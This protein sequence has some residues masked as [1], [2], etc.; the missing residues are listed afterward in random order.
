MAKP[1]AK[2]SRKKRLPPLETR[3]TFQDG[4]LVASTGKA[5]R[6]AQY[7]VYDEAT[8]FERNLKLWRKTGTDADNDLRDLWVHEMRQVQRVMSYSGA[9]D[10]IVDIIEFVEDE[11]NFG[12]LL[13]HAG[14]PLS[15]KREHVSSQHWLKN[16][17]AVRA[18]SLFWQNF[19]RVVWALGIIHAQGLVH[20]NIDTAAIMTEGADEP[21]FQLTGFEWSLRVAADNPNP[22]HAKKA[23]KVVS[24]RPLK[25]SF[26]EDWK[27][28]GRL[29]G[30][31]LDTGIRSSGELY[32]LGKLKTPISLSNSERVLLKRLAAPTRTDN[33]EAQ[34]IVR[35]IDD[36]IAEVGRS[37]A[38]RAG[39]LVLMF[40]PASKLGEAVYDMTGGQIAVD[41]YRRQL[42]WVRADLDGGATLLAP[43]DFEPNTSKLQLIT[44]TMRYLLVPFRQEG[45]VTWDIGVCVTAEPRPEALSFHEQEE[46][47]LA[48]PIEVVGASRFAQEARAR[49]G[50]DALDWS[51]FASTRTSR[52][53]GGR[54]DLI[55]QAL[56]LIQV[57]EAVVK[58]L[59]VYPIEIIKE[60]SEAGRQ[61]VLLRGAR[62]NDR[63]K[64]AKRI[65]LIDTHT[66]LK[67]LFEDDQRDG[68]GKWRI[69]QAASL[70]ASRRED[71]TATF[72]QIE[73]LNGKHA[74][75]FELDEGLPNGQTLFLRAERD[76]GTEN[77]IVRR[78]KIIK[79]LS[80]RVDLAEMLDN[81][82]RVRRSS[83]LS[84]DTKNTN[85]KHLMD[86][87]EP[88][89]SS[90]AGLW[91]TLPAY[92]VVGP[93]GVGK[94][95][96]ATEVVRRR[97]VED[98]STRML[99]TAQGHDALDHLQEKVEETLNAA[100]LDLIVARSSTPD[101]K[102]GA[103]D[104]QHTGHAI[105]RVLS[106]SKLAQQLPVSARDRI[107]SLAEAVGRVAQSRDASLRDERVGLN[108][109]SSLVLDAANVVVSTL[110]S[111]DVERLVEAREQFDWVVVE[112]AAK[113]LGPE[114][115]G[116]LSLSGRR[117]LIGDH[118]QLP[119]FEADR[120][121]KILIDHGRVAEVVLIA[122]QYVGTLLRDGELNELNEVADN[123]GRL[124]EIADI[125]LRLLEPFR[126]VVSED[127]RRARVD[128]T[129]RPVS[130]TLTQQR[131]MD[132]AIAEIVSRS[133]YLG[134]LSTEHN[135]AQEAKKAPVGFHCKSLSTSP[136][137]VIDFPH[138]SATGVGAKYEH[139][140]PR[141]H[142]P[143][144]V[145]AVTEILRR[146][147]PDRMERHEKSPSLAVL[148]F[149]K[150]QVEKLNEKIDGAI[151]AGTLA[152]LGGFVPAA[153]NGAWANTV[154]GFQG[155]EAD[156]VILS[157]VRNNSGSG[158]SA[159]GFLR[160][161]RRWN[162]ALSRAKS[163]LVIV[164]SL[165]FLREAV[166]GVNPDGL[167]HDLAFL[168]SV[169]E[170][171][172]EL[173]ERPCGDGPAPAARLLPKDLGVS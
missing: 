40:T 4:A 42:D 64:I 150:A 29:I 50:P 26:E 167:D 108:A 16:L 7:A 171:I 47:E 73:E 124:R 94:T 154:D 46:H 19:K 45:S 55:Q 49:L 23:D 133:F 151:K 170:V 136:V 52:V 164:G 22:Q 28:L 137:I 144:E 5:L 34:S 91:E 63:D 59:E 43:R 135:R 139:Y 166:R 156:I 12:V 6:S 155:N 62:D 90:L 129:H 147:R 87:D 3:F 98:S 125:G 37:G 126:S 149:Y 51:A 8:G 41:E 97:F 112:E 157:L 104:V 110:N 153:T 89:R 30:Q 103:T 27:S 11:E 160:D 9:S 102:A 173:L 122:D 84:I 107:I 81:V 53:S 111:A 18:R 39:T 148:S 71:V 119:P 143:A 168:T 116:A 114:L 152:H 68:D 141:F 44:T 65:G 69:S 35:A 92:F 14:Q 100:K 121:T 2:K 15:F 101:R 132:P 163:K 21:D 146:L 117:L 95:K 36:V 165:A 85:D 158:V 130:S 66:S 128:L 1:T 74:Y 140:R 75:R 106:E 20:G 131:R 33:L 60:Q 96:L 172:N 80:T 162:V 118:H 67:R 93:P 120:L 31:L 38:A 82:W 54:L 57:I 10:V 138:V 88:K 113:A 145:R 83:R 99:V 58:A 127:E 77:Q 115:V 56:L 142:N 17:G 70:G 134:G 76:V 105:L 109:V 123:E 61:F 48:Q 32:N 78:L 86:L 161:R 13:E 169:D 25:Y 79:G 72:T 159:L 24:A